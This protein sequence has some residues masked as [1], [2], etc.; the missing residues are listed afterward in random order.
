MCKRDEAPLSLI[1]CPTC[2]GEGE[3]YHSTW[4]GNW[5]EPPCAIYRPCDECRGE[6]SLIGDHEQLNEYDLDEMAPPIE[7]YEEPAGRIVMGRAA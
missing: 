2:G 4:P 1:Q 5:Y 6:G 7:A 3:V